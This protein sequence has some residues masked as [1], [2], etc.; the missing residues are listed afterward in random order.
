[1]VDDSRDRL[2]EALDIKGCDEVRQRSLPRLLVVIGE[3]AL[4]M[5]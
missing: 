5:A 4:L 2:A 1:M 3:L